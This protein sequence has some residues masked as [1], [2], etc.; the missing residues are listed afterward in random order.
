MLSNSVGIYFRYIENLY[1]VLKVTLTDANMWI[2][3]ILEVCVCVCVCVGGGGGG[4]G[5]GDILNIKSWKQLR[6]TAVNLRHMQLPIPST[7]TLM[8]LCI[9]ISIPVQIKVILND[10]N[11]VCRYSINPNK[12][13][14]TD[15]K[16]DSLDES[17]K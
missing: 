9:P 5:G 4:G 1:C 11:N 16:F 8:A 13:Q 14:M 6:A 2:R 12:W 17:M 10:P 3:Y 15:R 7:I